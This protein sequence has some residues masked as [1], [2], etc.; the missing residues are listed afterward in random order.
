MSVVRLV[1]S[2]DLEA[3]VKRL[4]QEELPL[5]AHT[6]RQIAALSSSNSSSLADMNQAI[7]NDGTLTA[8]VLRLANSAYHNPTGEPIKTVSRAIV[9]L[10]FDAV[11]N[12]ALSIKILDTALNGVR[13]ER[14]MQELVRMF[15]AAYQARE[16]VTLL[17][18][19]SATEEL[20]IAA[21][22]HRLG[23][24]TFW[25]FPYGYED[26]LDFEYALHATEEAA[27][28]S[29]LGFTLDQLT[30][31]I[32]RHWDL[33]QL[34]PTLEDED[35]SDEEQKRLRL[36][37]RLG[38][39]I[40]KASEEDWTSDDMQACF[41]TLRQHTKLTLPELKQWVY[42]NTQHTLQAIGNMG[43][44]PSQSK[45]TLP[46][47]FKSPISDPQ[48]DQESR[49]EQF[50]MQLSIL[51]DVA[52]LLTEEVNLNAVLGMV[53]EG[54]YRALAMDRVVFAWVTPD[55]RQLVAKYVLGRHRQLLMQRFKFE[56]QGHQ[57]N[58]FGYL[59]TQPHP[60]WINRR[61]RYQLQ[62][63]ITPGVQACV[64]QHEFFAMPIHVHREP[65]GLVY[66]DRCVR[67]ELL[68][69]EEFKIFSHLTEHICIALKMLHT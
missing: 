37:L 43:V 22:L 38:C 32:S 20:F 68:Q 49:A 53:L 62:G 14:A 35:Y 33:D 46:P 24:L 66:A 13:H 17:G 54:V 42:G 55:G 27:E 18:G 4:S 25:C 3:W 50:N 6:A 51:R 15:H 36:A 63:M 2:P 10:G 8:R 65:K 67:G 19:S 59:T 7:L 28:R 52:H 57:E 41:E 40:A 64:G 21:M 45:L 58:L 69:E 12:I 31:H 60:Q 5:F 34:L 1:Q 56:L 30:E 23:H 61:R 44:D 47:H 48:V 9:V 11:R 16:L 39:K 26:T 29:V